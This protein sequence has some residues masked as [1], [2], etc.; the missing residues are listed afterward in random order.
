MLPSLCCERSGILAGELVERE[1]DAA[2]MDG[3]RTSGVCF[4]PGLM[5]Y[6]FYPASWGEGTYGVCCVIGSASD[7]VQHLG[8]GER[9]A[10]PTPLA[11]TLSDCRWSYSL[12]SANSSSV[13]SYYSVQTDSIVLLFISSFQ[14]C[15]DR[16]LGAVH[17]LVVISSVILVLN[18]LTVFGKGSKY[19]PK[20]GSRYYPKS[21]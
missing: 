10:F 3:C 8:R 17:V 19:F 21:H 12:A 6:L 18:I 5:L 16:S 13:S 1:G 15:W 11:H 9:W 14:S 4:A 20:K 7:P 2:R